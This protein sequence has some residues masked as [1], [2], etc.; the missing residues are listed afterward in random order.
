VDPVKAARLGGGLLRARR[1][2]TVEEA[3]ASFG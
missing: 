2:K 3:L 1:I